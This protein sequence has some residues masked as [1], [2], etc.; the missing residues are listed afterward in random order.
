MTRTRMVLLITALLCAAGLGRAGTA[1]AA[2]LVYAV[3]T[4]NRLVSFNG[5]TPSAIS[6]IAFTGLP[7]GEQIVGLD[8]RQPGGLLRAIAAQAQRVADHIAG[9]SR[10]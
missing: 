5:D 9:V 2:E 6:R 4:Q 7:A 1:S 3:D 10:D 8:V